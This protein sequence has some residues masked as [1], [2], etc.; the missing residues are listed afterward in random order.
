[1][2]I[3]AVNFS[4]RSSVLGALTASL[5]PV[6]PAQARVADVDS[7][8][9]LRQM[10]LDVVVPYAP[11]GGAD[12]LGRLVA[13]AFSAA[14]AQKVVVANA[15]GAA[16]TIGSRQVAQSAADGC[17]WLISGIGSHVIAPQWQSVPY[18]AIKDFEH[19]AILGGSP[20]V[21]V[22]HLRK[23]HQRLQDLR[24][25]LNWA[26]PGSGSHGHLLGAAI[27]QQLGLRDTVHVPY[28]GG[29]MAM[30]DLLGG[31]VDL[32]VMTLTSFLPH[33]RNPLVKAM[34]VTSARSIEQLPSVPTFAELGFRDLTAFTWFGLSA[35]R[36]LREEW[37]LWAS[38][39][40]RRHYAS[41]SV[42][43]RLR[44]QA[45]GAVV[46]RPEQAQTFMRE[47]WTRWGRVIASMSDSY[48][49]K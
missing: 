23:D 18:D 49:E 33:A 47:E 1:M 48:R 15:P 40:L 41:E 46:L 37:S 44:Q 2:S 34:A 38:A 30:N 31:H 10:T 7:A 20:S 42:Q 24:S 36:G 21:L 26:S 13:D 35:P 9:L 4:R 8:A 25:P 6:W 39:A 3:D 17:N 16:G 32:A 14:G 5:M 29:A 28:K 12:L 11:G 45:M 22:T 27:M 19:L 43:E